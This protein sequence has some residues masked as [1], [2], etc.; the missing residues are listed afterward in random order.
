MGNAH[1]LIRPDAVGLD[2]VGLDAMSQRSWRATTF[3]AAGTVSLLVLSLLGSLVLWVTL[4]WALLSWSPTLVVSGSMSPAVDEGDVVLI[5]AVDAGAVGRDTVVLYTHPD[6]GRVLHRVIGPHPRGGYLLQGDANPHP[7]T[8]P[9]HPGQLH[10]A[11]ILLVP[12]VGLPSLWL[13]RGNY[14]ALAAAAALLVGSCPYCPKPST[15]PSIRGSVGGDRY[16]PMSCPLP[17]STPS[18]SSWGPACMKPS[19]IG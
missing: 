7:D 17:P 5:R 4:P 2:A 1:Q 9:V 19:W 14:P 16:S 11:A 6:L 13:V 3:F 10:G 12:W 8:A 15:L 18:S